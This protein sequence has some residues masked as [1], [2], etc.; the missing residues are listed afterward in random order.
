MCRQPVSLL[1]WHDCGPQGLRWPEEWS[2]KRLHQAEKEQG[3]RDPR[4][5]SKMGFT[6]PQSFQA[7][8]QERDEPERPIPRRRPAGE[9]SQRQVGEA[10]GDKCQQPEALAKFET[11]RAKSASL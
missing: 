3:R 9:D 2:P 6:A 8:S 1:G 10:A 7:E 4:E 11:E 5:E